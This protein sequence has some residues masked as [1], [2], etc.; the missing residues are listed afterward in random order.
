MIKNLFFLGSILLGSTIMAQNVVFNENFDSEETQNLWTI[1]D[2]DGDNDTWE[3]VDAVEAESPSFSGSFA[4]SWSWYFDALTPD[5]T[6]TSPLITLPEGELELSFKVSAA[7][8]ELFEEHYAVYVIPANSTFTGNETAV[9]EETL[10]AGYFEVAKTVKVDISDFAG[11]DVQLIFRHYDC[12]DVL[13]IGVDDV[14]IEQSD[15]AVDNVTRTK[16]V[17]YKENEVVK[18]KGFDNVQKIKVFDLTGK[19]I[20]ETNQSEV[21]ISNFSKGIYIVNFYNDKEVVSRKI[22]K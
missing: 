22:V 18:I 1:G 8:D 9:Y 19:K 3:F 14:K 15:L 16:A 21:N 17:V 5:N 6:L 10:D 20:I 7:D 4:W 12:T 13:F 11:Q 2:R